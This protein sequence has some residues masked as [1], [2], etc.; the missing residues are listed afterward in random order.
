[1]EITDFRGTCVGRLVSN[2][3]ET[4]LEDA[5]RNVLAS[6]QTDPMNHFSVAGLSVYLEGNE[7]NDMG[8]LLRVPGLVH[9]TFT[10]NDHDG[11]QINCATQGVFTKIWNWSTARRVV[12]EATQPWY[13]AFPIQWVVKTHTNTRVHPAFFLIPIASHALAS[14]KNPSII[15]RAMQAVWKALDSLGMVEESKPSSK[16]H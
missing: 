5:E 11:N 2:D 8:T 7:E 6:A 16:R 13:R 3:S 10:A 14:A 1:M 12:V 4:R 15:R 9:P